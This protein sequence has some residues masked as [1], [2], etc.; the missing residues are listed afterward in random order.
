MFKYFDKEAVERARLYLDEIGSSGAYCESQG[1]SS[2]R[3]NVAKFISARDSHLQTKSNI[4]LTQGASAGINYVLHTILSSNSGVMIP[5]PQYPLYSATITLLGAHQINYH[6]NESQDWSINIDQ[7]KES[8]EKARGRGIEPRVLCIINPGNPTGNLFSES[9]LQQIVKLCYDQGLV[10]LADEVY[11]ANVYDGKFISARKVL[12]D[13]PEPYNQVELFS[14]HS[15]SKGLLG[16]CGKRGGYFDCTNI[17]SEVLDQIFKFCTI[18]LCPNIQGQVMVDLMINPPSKGQQSY[19]QFQEEQ[20]KVFD[21]LKKRS[22]MLYE[23]FNSLDGVTC[24][25]PR[26]AMYL[27]PRLSLP[28]KF[29]KLAK[30]CNVPADE[31]YCMEM[32]EATG[33]C[34]VPG[35]GFG[36]EENTF[37][38][39]STFLPP[40]EEFPSFI[41]K[42]KAFHREFMEKYQ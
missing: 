13:M 35:S 11:Q 20:S 39:R 40:I 7:M 16:E 4:F 19:A 41:Q 18:S 22:E 27:F 24:T 37:H 2:V 32:L 21:S 26:G 9:D 36:Q 33:V 14:F 29:L 5:I 25:K 17:D 38:F 8:L 6:L 1:I 15:T 42:I 12:L 3:E 23:A 28:P 34:V 30:T 31:L 10:L